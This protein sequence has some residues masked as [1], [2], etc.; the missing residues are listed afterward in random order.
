MLLYCFNAGFIVL[1]HPF[2]IVSTSHGCGFRFFALD[3]TAVTLVIGDV[4]EDV[5]GKSRHYVIWSNSNI[6]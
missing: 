4:A 5:L 1:V 6:I 2:H 3:N